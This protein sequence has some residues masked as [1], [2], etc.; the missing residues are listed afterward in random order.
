MHVSV[1]VF[2]VRERKKMFSVLGVRI[3][4]VL[5]PLS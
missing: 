4:R 1:G 5:E 3:K 2:M